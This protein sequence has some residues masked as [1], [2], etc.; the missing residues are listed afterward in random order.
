MKKM[1]ALTLAVFVVFGCCSIT[2]AGAETK[3]NAK[4][5]SEMRQKIKEL[6]K[7]KLK[8]ALSLDKETADKLFAAIDQHDAKMRELIQAMKDDIKDLK[9]A[10]D[11]NKGEAAEKAIV[12]KIAA[13]RKELLALKQTEM[14]ELQGIL[15]VSQQ[16]KYILFSVDFHRTIRKIM[17]EKRSGM[18]SKGD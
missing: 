5:M 15:S 4:E 8:E 9:Q 14:D 1:I 2:Y 16:A 12:D 18:G 6:K 13:A 17:A 3:Y 11:G 7:R 10:V